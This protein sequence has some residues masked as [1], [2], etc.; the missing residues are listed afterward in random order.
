MDRLET[1]AEFK[2]AEVD[3]DA[4]G[5]FEGYASTFGNVDQGGDIVER[6]AFAETLKAKAAGDIAMLFQHNSYG[7][8]IGDWLEMRENDRGL[9]VRGRL[10]L[11]DPD[12]AR[13]Y[14]ALSKGRIKGL[15]IGFRI[16]PGGAEW[17]K[18]GRTRRIK[19][20][21]LHEVSVVTFPMNT[22]A[23]VARV[24]S[25][26]ADVPV[27]RLIEEGLRDAGYSKSDA[28]KLVSDFK[29]KFGRGDPGTDDANT[30]ALQRLLSTLRT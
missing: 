21:D 20:V 24:K 14:G 17:D 26:T 6:G 18:S 8:P 4:K 1:T 30:A 25:L 23:Q 27:E 28:M 22:R 9:V 29:A 7:F 10:D 3:A 13:V 15:S 16:R 5:T 11:D 19:S 2:F 12:G